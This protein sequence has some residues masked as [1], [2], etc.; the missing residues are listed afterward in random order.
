MVLTLLVIIWIKLL[1]KSS[2]FKPSRKDT[3]NSAV[4]LLVQADVFWLGE[5]LISYWCVIRGD[6]QCL[7][8]KRNQIFPFASLLLQFLIL[9][10]L[11]CYLFQ[12]KVSKVPLSRIHLKHSARTVYIVSDSFNIEFALI[13]TSSLHRRGSVHD[14]VYNSLLAEDFGVQPQPQRFFQAYYWLHRNTGLESFSS[15]IDTS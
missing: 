2:F 14:S 8:Q 13:S 12:D 9:L 5:F 10:L 3:T 4:L 7:N 15:S 1:N 6:V 11:P